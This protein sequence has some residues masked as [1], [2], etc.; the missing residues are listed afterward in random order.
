[1]GVSHNPLAETNEHGRHDPARALNVAALFDVLAW[2]NHIDFEDL[3]AAERHAIQFHADAL[4]FS[5]L[6]AKCRILRSQL[7]PA[8]LPDIPDLTPIADEFCRQFL[9]QKNLERAAEREAQQ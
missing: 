6:R 9:V 4:A 1:M 5:A 7:Q 3:T 2:F 8:T